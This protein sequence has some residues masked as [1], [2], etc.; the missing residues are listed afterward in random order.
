MATIIQFRD[1]RDSTVDDRDRTPTWLVGS[2]LM[3]LA[4]VLGAPLIGLAVAALFVGGMAV[5]WWEERSLRPGE[6]AAIAS[7]HA[8]AVVLLSF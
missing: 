8:I 6:F 7:L 4:V 1:H 3:A 5:S 2:F